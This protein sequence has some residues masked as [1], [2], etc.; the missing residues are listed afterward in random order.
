MEPRSVLDCVHFFLCAQSLAAC[1]GDSDVSR[2]VKT[3]SYFLFSSGGA[4]GK[5]IS[6]SDTPAIW[7]SFVD[8]WVGNQSLRGI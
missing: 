5:C 1:S 4:F 6:R 8:F 3:H 2:I 7:E